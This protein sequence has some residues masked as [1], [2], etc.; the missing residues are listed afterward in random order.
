MVTEFYE[1]A[2]K[3]EYNNHGGHE[4]EDGGSG[5]CRFFLII[6]K[7]MYSLRL[8]AFARNILIHQPKRL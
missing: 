4:G 5:G 1:L 7:F 3:N 2:I 6:Q 8:C